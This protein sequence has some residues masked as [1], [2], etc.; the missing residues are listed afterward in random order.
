MTR[1]RF[2]H[3]AA[4]AAVFAAAACTK[5]RPTQPV[6]TPDRL[7]AG[8]VGPMQVNFGDLAADQVLS[9]PDKLWEILLALDGKEPA[10]D[11]KPDFRGLLTKLQ[12]YDPKSDIPATLSGLGGAYA[13][14][15]IEAA[16]RKLDDE[17]KFADENKVG[18]ESI[19]KIRHYYFNDDTAGGYI[20]VDTTISITLNGNRVWQRQ[21]FWAIAVAPDTYQVIKKKQDRNNP[22]PDTVMFSDEKLADIEA[23]LLDHKLF[24]KGPGIIVIA[25]YEDGVLLPQSH[26]DYQSGPDSCIDL[27]FRGRPRESELPTQKDYCLGRCK[28][29]YIINTGA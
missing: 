29:P 7:S 2:V 13:R 15:L 10:P 18:L 25:V 6:V 4:I 26:A 21:H 12:G 1:Y 17:D 14:A 9:D 22:F 19:G 3:L 20:E 8:E 28:H 16:V 11:A 27:M 24:A 23:R 5:P